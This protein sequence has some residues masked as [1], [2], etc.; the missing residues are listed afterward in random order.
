MGISRFL[1]I[2]LIAI[3]ATTA[4]VAPGFVLQSSVVLAASEPS[5]AAIEAAKLALGGDFAAAGEAA[6]RSDDPAAIKLV[7]LIFLRDRPND[8][9]YQRIIAFLDT[10][11]KWPLSEA[12]LK[13]AERSLYVNN[14]PP[15]LI[16]QHFAK[17]KPVTD[18]GSLALARALVATG[19][20]PG[21]R[22]QVQKVWADPEATA[23]LEKQVSS[24][25][26][27]LLT[28]DDNKRRMWRLVYAL[29][30]NA[31]IRVSKRLPAEYQKAAAVAQKLV[32]G[33][34]GADKLYGGLS[35]GMRGQLGMRYALAR[36][37]RVN[38]KY[39]KARDVLLTVPGDAGKMGDAEAWWVERRIVAR[40]SIGLDD[41]KPARRAAYKIAAAHGFENGDGAVEGEFLAGWIALRHLNDPQTA[42]GHFQRLGQIAPSRSEKA[43]A[44][45]WTGRAHEAMGDKGNAKAAYKEASAYSTTYYGQLAR[46]KIGLG[47]VPEEI[48]S[49]KASSAAEAKVNKDEVV[50][51]FK[52]MEQAG[53]QNDLYMF[54][55]SFANRFDTADEMNA[56]ASIVWDAGGASMAVRLAKAAAQQ[57]VDIDSWGY[58]VRAL[59]GWKRVGKPVEK[60]LVF[61]LARQESEFNPNAGSKVGAQGLMQ[62]MP[63]TAK[64]IAKQ[65]G[66]KYNPS[67]LMDP[68]VNVTLGAAHLGDLVADH[69]GS[70]VLTLVSYNAGPRRSR[71]W[72]KEYGDFRAGQVDP[73]DW[74]ESI[75]FQETRQYVQKV[76]QNLHVYRS[77][78]APKTV[79]PM[80]ADL[81]RGAR[82]G[83]LDAASTAPSADGTTGAA[84][85]AAG[86]TTGGCAKASIA[87][88]IGGCN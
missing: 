54:L 4:L 61:A 24:E 23:E 9:G 7:E 41:P 16:L 1:R 67:Q 31:A 77:R 73:I 42:L 88:L 63:G 70:Y 74:V 71:E 80:T 83:S 43:R 58:P 33:E 3:A 35:S 69:D 64:L 65:H 26:G 44:G 34:K 38:E 25:F 17:R 85:P 6:Q 48:E 50:R 60:P 47:K 19:D 36:Y 68:V 53:T 78:L 59:P 76:M 84:E 82:T 79:R 66:I 72:I 45:Y 11:P 62:I 87:S 86:S 75:P 22:A 20:M 40:R 39:A 21:A 13:R 8:A 18:E 29:E 32:R 51:A 81:M 27:E 5:P 55:W 57:N 49:G 12:L 46:E 37:Y 56:A 28:A 30:T 14:E 15:E 52:I 2:S 10:A